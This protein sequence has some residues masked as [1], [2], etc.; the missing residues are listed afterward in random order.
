MDRRMLNR[1]RADRELT[2]EQIATL[3]GAKPRQGDRL[4]KRISNIAPLDT[5]T[6]SD[7]SFLDNPKYTEAIARTHAG[8]CLVAAW[9][10]SERQSP[11]S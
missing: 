2:I 8:A 10:R 5:A 4:D 11:R 3:T 6:A 1:L 9:R 7:I